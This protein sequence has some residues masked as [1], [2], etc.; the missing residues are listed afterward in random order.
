MRTDRVSTVVDWLI[1]INIAV[2][3][4]EIKPAFR[5]GA[6]PGLILNSGSLTTEIR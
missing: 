6:N 2:A 4:F 1:D 5:V 3:D